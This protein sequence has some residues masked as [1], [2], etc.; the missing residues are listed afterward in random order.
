MEKFR[1]VT[2]RVSDRDLAA[3][4]AY[5]GTGLTETM[6]AGLKM[7]ATM[8]VQQELRK[9]RGTVKFSTRLADI[10]RDRR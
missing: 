4:R 10:K 7:L 3:A 8:H 6:R 9:L 5:T 1:R 2:V